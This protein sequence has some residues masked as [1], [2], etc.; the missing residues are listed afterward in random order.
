MQT[1]FLLTVHVEKVFGYTY[2]CIV[3]AVLC[4]Q[5]LDYMILRLAGMKMKT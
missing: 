3:T 1:M 5:V 2:Q 4:L